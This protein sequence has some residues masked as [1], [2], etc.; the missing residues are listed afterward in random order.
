M[1]S[2]SACLPSGET[3]PGGQWPAGLAIAL[4]SL[5]SVVF[6]AYHPTIQAAD[7]AE[8]VE[9][10][11]QEARLD[12]IVH[13]AL[14]VLMGILLYGFSCL[15]TRLGTSIFTVRAGLVAYAMG[16]GAMVAAALIDGFLI[17]DFVRRYQGRPADA[18][19]I[20]RHM[21]TLCSLA[22]GVCARMGVIATSL[23]VMLWSL[24]LIRR[25]GVLRVV[26]T[27]GCIVGALP[28]AALLLG[29]LPMNKHG[30]LAF[31]L[32][33]TAWSLALGVQMI[34]GRV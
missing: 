3:L 6:M 1:S 19:E 28:V 22:I 20:M 18:L 34:R 2:E 11:A 5:L 30:V 8:F 26:G 33:Q 17:P 12:G 27:L 21:L 24:S 25:P 9:A 23:A 4:G 31:V 7:P 16:T 29:Y 32:G 14:I 10:M 13:A 15:A